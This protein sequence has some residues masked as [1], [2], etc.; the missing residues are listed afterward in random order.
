M[1]VDHLCAHFVQ[2]LIEA[3]GGE[4]FEKRIGIPVGTNAV[5]HLIALSIGR[6]HFVHGVDVVLTVAVDGDGNVAAVLCLHESGQYGVLVSAIP[7]LANAKKMGILM[8][9]TGDDVPGGILTAV[10][11]KQHPAVRGN[12]SRSGQVGELFQKLRS[13]NGQHR[14]LVIAGNDEIENGKFHSVSFLCA[15]NHWRSYYNAY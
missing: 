1:I 13:G 6:H 10:V 12:V 8:G 3:L 15:R 11:H 7:A 5:D 4:A 14:L 2:Q 9:E